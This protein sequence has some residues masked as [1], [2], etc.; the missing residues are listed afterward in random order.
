[1]KDPCHPFR[2]TG[3][4]DA[5]LAHYDRQA[6]NWPVAATSQMMETSFGQT[7]VRISGPDDGPPMVLLPGDTEHSLA[8]IPVV[9]QFSNHY[10]T[11]AVDQIYDIG[12]SIYSRPITEP[13]DYVHWLGDL[14]DS[15]A[16]DNVDLVGHSYGGWQASLFALAHPTRL[17]KLVLLSPAVTVLRPGLG[18]LFRAIVY[19]RVPTRFVTRR[20]LYWYA[21]EAS[22]RPDTVQAIDNMVEESLLARK[23]FKRRKFVPPTVLTD[24]QWRSLAVPTLFLVGDREVTYPADKAIQRLNRVAPNVATRLAA[25]E[26]HHLTIV[27]PD[28]VVDNVLDFLA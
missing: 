1:M 5:Y 23:C 3:A 8:W 28:W 6:R 15:L 2:S 9:E 11:Y 16:L 27:K 17:N 14:F 20:Y 25:D 18:L 13:A 7:F 24:E 4:R 21:P 19:D 10:R 12:R 22:S 26:D